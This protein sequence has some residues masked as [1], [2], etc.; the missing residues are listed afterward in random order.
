MGS[1]GSKLLLSPGK[2][3]SDKDAFT[4]VE[5]LTQ[6]HITISVVKIEVT[7]GYIIHLLRVYHVERLMLRQLHNIHPIPHHTNPK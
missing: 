6:H 1:G 5:S 3:V 2:L 7:Q 4:Q